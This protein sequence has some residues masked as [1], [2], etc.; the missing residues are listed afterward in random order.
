M[1]TR[2]FEA[3]L[4][5]IM[6][7]HIYE[8]HQ[9]DAPA[10]ASASYILRTLRSYTPIIGLIL[11][12]VAIGYLIVA[13]A[14]YILAPSSRVTSVP[15]RLDWE[16]ATRG[17]YPNGQRFSPVEVI[18]TPVLVKTFND[19]DL[20]RYTTYNDFARSIIVLQSNLAMEV[21]AREYQA[22]LADTRLS[23]VDRERIQADYLM[24]LASLNKNE[25]AINYIRDGRKSDSVPETVARKVINDILMNWANFAAN[26]QHVLQY[27]VAV[28]SPDVVSVGTSASNP[29]IDVVMMRDK[30][31]RLIFNIDQIR[32]LPAAELARTKE[33][34]TLAD[35]SV[36]LDDVV[37][38]RLDPLVVRIAAAG[39]D[40]RT[41][42]L[43]FLET[44]LA[45]DE[46][47]LQ[48]QEQKAAAVQ[49]TLAMYVDV[50]QTEPDT[51]TGTAAQTAAGQR[52]QQD[53]ET[54]TPQVSEGFLDRL[55][56][57]AARSVDSE[58]RQ[59]LAEEYRAE[60][61]RVGPMQEAVTYD[62]DI[63]GLIRGA[64]G[65]GAV[66][67]AS[68]AAS[69]AALRG[70][71]RLLAGKVG[72]IHKD[73]SKNLNPATE[74]VTLNAP[75]S[76]VERA[77]SLKQLAMYGVLT[78]ALALP[79]IVVLCLVHAHIKREEE[80]EQLADQSPSAIVSR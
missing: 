79:I 58:F 15:F 2:F 59:R 73:V 12:A 47:R 57:L 56:Q 74:L 54:V 13:V 35:L 10:T 43:R 31:Q 80:E 5:N 4:K 64:S 72:E 33:G 7:D 63:L 28:L 49:E 60:L 21:L 65:G 19:N 34:L 62:K 29:I 24:K 50:Q 14:L 67:P 71:V 53:A 16:G 38:Y 55:V 27:R 77:T 11:A 17:E 20:G 36:R 18:S 22:R 66:D 68:V 23:A 8:H 25:Y 40:S 52:R 45:H 6:P 48:A 76:R 37:R 26:E 46:R 30:V 41:E 9:P 70:E 78:L 32:G 44:Q 61:L 39:L 42:T 75:F 51:R 3:N 69:I 1:L